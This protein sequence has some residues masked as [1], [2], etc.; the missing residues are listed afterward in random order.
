M[1][2]F[3]TKDNIIHFQFE[4]FSHSNTPV[5]LTEM[6][7]YMMRVI[8]NT[9][10]LNCENL[11]ELD[12]GGL[13]MLVMIYIHLKKR[14]KMLRLKNLSGQP[15]NLLIALDIYHFFQE[16]DVCHAQYNLQNV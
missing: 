12:A 5:V 8:G 11:R 16:E 14:G 10:N 1:I 9:V 15:K 2:D 3:S 4:E 6:L 7:D 13:G